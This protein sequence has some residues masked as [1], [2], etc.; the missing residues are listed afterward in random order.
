MEARLVRFLWFSLPRNRIDLV[1]R[2]A[3]CE[4]VSS[5]RSEGSAFL[6]SSEKSH[7]SLR[8]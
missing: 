4:L 3:L 5:G 7:P 6:P 8:S 1:V 2:I